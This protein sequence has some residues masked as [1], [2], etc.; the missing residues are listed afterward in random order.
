[1]W[2]E[3]PSGGFC[4]AAW[5]WPV[6]SLPARSA[7]IVVPGIALE[8]RTL[9]VGLRP[10]CESLAESGMPTLLVHLEGTM[11]SSGNL[12]DRSVVD[13]WPGDVAVAIEHARV[14]GFQHLFLI[15]VRLGALLV[16]EAA[17]T[18]PG[19]AGL[20]LW[21]PAL[22]GRRYGRELT[23]LGQAAPF[24]DDGESD[25]SV[26]IGTAPIGRDLLKAVG[27]RRLRSP[28]L[29]AGLPVLLI[30]DPD[31]LDLQAVERVMPA[32]AITHRVSPEVTPWLYV[33]SDHSRVPRLDIQAI[34]T[35]AVGSAARFAPVKL[36]RPV[37]SA[38]H[39]FTHDGL[40]ISEEHVKIAADGVRGVLTTP[41]GGLATGRP[42]WLFVLSPQPGTSF[43][44]FARDEAARGHASLRIDHT[45]HGLSRRRR[46]QSW[47]E[48]YGRSP[49]GEVRR[50]ADWLLA[51]GASSVVLVGFCAAAE[52]TLRVRP[53]AGIAGIVAFN[54]PLFLGSPTWRSTDGRF[55]PW[56]MRLIERSD[57]RRIFVRARFRI[58]TQIWPTSR[59]LRALPNG[60]DDST[61]VVLV[62]CSIDNGLKFLRR[63]GR[64]QLQRTGPGGPVRVNVYEQLGH[65]LTGLRARARVFEDMRRLGSELWS[66]VP[67]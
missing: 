20:V 51:Q 27:G 18:E 8:D 12:L 21:S 3:S 11:N 60:P 57:T 15:G 10:L 35:W 64:R 36:E 5:F 13:A 41:A 14:L 34:C 66:T 37:V 4:S 52:T 58:R 7:A 62:F 48:Y 17:A 63:F 29:P 46:R 56:Y 43:V 24:A 2:L 25:G 61:Q 38:V 9:T 1:M 30:D 33:V 50:A 67:R 40:R 44:Q 23:M 65:G 28:E 16:I 45:S 26:V 32:A 55:G 19:V 47:G 42:A 59:S 39:E 53:R 6:G 31:R 54:A 22:D 49:V